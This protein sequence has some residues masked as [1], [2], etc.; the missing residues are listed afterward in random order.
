MFASDPETDSLLRAATSHGASKDMQAA[1]M[2]LQAATSRMHYSPVSYPIETWLRL[3]L[4]LQKAG[5]Y[6]EALTEFEKLISE[7]EA[8]IARAFSHQSKAKQRIFCRQEIE[9]IRGKMQLAAEREN[10]KRPH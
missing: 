2:C 3:P 6:Q 7:T 4:Y 8:R 9:V 1:V 10:R 5:R